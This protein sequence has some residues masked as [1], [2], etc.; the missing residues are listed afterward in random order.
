[1]ENNYENLQNIAQEGYSLEFGTVL[2]RAFDNFKKSFGIIGV[3]I[4]LITALLVVI[5]FGLLGA[6]VGFS[7]INSTL[8]DFNPMQFTG[9]SLVIYF[10]FTIVIS[11]IM[12]V[13]NAGFYR[14]ADQ[15]ENNEAIEIGTLF[16]YFKTHHFKELF[17]ATAIIT[18]LT[19]G[20]AITF[21]LIGYNFIGAIITYCISFL[22]F[23]T[24]PLITFAN[25]KAIE[26]IKLGIKLVLK[27]PLMNLGLLLVA[28]I[29]AMFGL[30]AFCI[31]IFF[32]I[33]FL[34]SM[35]YVIYTTIYP[36]QQRDSID[37]IGTN[38]YE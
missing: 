35:I 38:E 28:L 1:M 15:A 8:V 18:T 9:I 36:N 13:F 31:G 30:I 24:V 17:L 34:F 16:Y 19:S 21:E 14:M 3:G 4:L 27:N 23:L 33:P 6:I 2:E 22:T 29:L 5:F 26:A 11:S 25:L 32:T 37:Q 10:L 20:V 12:A 7:S